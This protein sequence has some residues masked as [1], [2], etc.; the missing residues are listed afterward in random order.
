M[1]SHGESEIARRPFA[2]LVIAPPVDGAEI[3]RLLGVDAATGQ[4]NESE[5]VRP[6]FHVGQR[7]LIDHSGSSVY[8]DGD[9]AGEGAAQMEDN[10]STI[11]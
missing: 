10:I 9:A 8:D 5:R 3:D 1:A 6:D 4:L 2:E 7:R 11:G